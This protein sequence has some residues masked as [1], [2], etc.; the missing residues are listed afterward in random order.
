MIAKPDY[1]FEVFARKSMNGNYL[2]I[3]FATNTFVSKE[4]WHRIAN[5]NYLFGM[6]SLEGDLQLKDLNSVFFYLS[7]ALGYLYQQGI[8]EF[9]YYQDY[10]KGA[11]TTFDG[12]IY[13]ATEFVK[14]KDKPKPI[15]Y[16]ACGNPCSTQE[17]VCEDFIN[18]SKSNKW[19]ALVTK[20][21]F[22]KVVK[23]LKDEDQALHTKIDKI[24]GL[25]SIN[26][27]KRG[28]RDPIVEF[29]LHL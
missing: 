8:A 24:K 12:V 20:C 2:P 5:E 21:E 28:G 6:E 4:D 14:G 23:E 17:P 9:S 10:P 25:E 18:P 13:L 11:V 26:V 22:D 16:D 15:K 29:V 3:E 27:I 1:K 19:C 7:S